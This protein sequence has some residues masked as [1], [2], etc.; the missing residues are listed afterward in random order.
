[1][2]VIPAKNPATGE[3]LKVPDPAMKTASRETYFLPPEGRDVGGDN[4]FYWARLL[5]DGDVT[6]GQRSDDAPAAPAA[7]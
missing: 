1:M 3:P 4:E 2:Y 7:G 6:L 5:M